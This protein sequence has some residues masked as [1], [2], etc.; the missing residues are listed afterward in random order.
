MF[1]IVTDFFRKREPNTP[2]LKSEDIG[3]GMFTADG[4]GKV[5]TGLFPQTKNVARFGA[6]LVKVA[7]RFKIDNKTRMA[8]FL[9]QTGHESG[10]YRALVENLN[11]S[12]E[13]LLKTFPRYFK[14]LA[15]A[16]QYARK[17]DKIANRVYG[18]RMGNGAEHSGDGFKFRGRGV[19]QLTGKENVTTFAR[20]M[21]MTVDAALAYLET[22]EGAVMSAGWFWSRNNL[23]QFADSGDFTTLT[24][25]INGGLIGYDDRVAKWNKAKTLLA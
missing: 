13:G 6:P 11:Y 16:Q 18:G 23:N 3:G 2:A 15:E 14:T 9:A 1:R 4:L 25:R 12:A 8:A 5:L 20:D 19:I 22:D 21:N 7:E 24:R 17:P 10:G